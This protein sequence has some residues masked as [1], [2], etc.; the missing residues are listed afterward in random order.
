MLTGVPYSLHHLPKGVVNWQWRYSR[1]S[2]LHLTRRQGY[3]PVQLQRAIRLDNSLKH[4]GVRAHLFILLCDILLILCLPQDQI[5]DPAAADVEVVLIAAVTENGGVFATGILKRVRENRHR[6]EIAS[7]VHRLREADGGGGSP[8]R[9]EDDGTERVAK[10]V[11]KEIADRFLGIP[12]R[13]NTSEQMMA[14]GHEKRAFVR[15]KMRRASGHINRTPFLAPEVGEIPNVSHWL[16]FM[17]NG[18]Q[19]SS[20]DQTFREFFRYFNS[21]EQRWVGQHMSEV[22]TTLDREESQTAIS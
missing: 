9:I 10:D 16:D 6:V 1:Y 7:I 21:P 15:L 20:R 14:T 12:S 3:F 11:A 18:L 22:S 4:H 2:D 13:L 5:D 17:R 19:I 8:V